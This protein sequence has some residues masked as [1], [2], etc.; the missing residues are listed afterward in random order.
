MR[1]MYDSV[2]ASAIPRSAEMVAGYVDGIY[3]WSPQDWA[4]FPD[5]VKV[6]ISAV[7]ATHLAQV[8]D[9]EQGCIWP[10]ER[11]V[12]LV[13]AARRA[14]IDPTVYVNERN[15]WGPTKAAFDRAGVAHPH[16]WL[17][18]YDGRADY[19]TPGAVARQYAHPHDGDGVADRPWETGGHYDLSAVRDYWPGVDEEDTM[20]QDEREALF[21]IRDI[22]ESANTGGVVENDL[23]NMGQWFR[24]LYQAVISVHRGQFLPL[25]EGDVGGDLTWFQEQSELALQP[26]LDAIAASGGGA[27]PI[28]YPALVAAQ[29]AS[30]EYMRALGEAV[31][32]AQDRNARDNDPTT[33]PTT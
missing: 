12:P 4:R 30:P 18:N 13:V 8:F 11:V 1:T 5:A 26:V 33:G 27:G 7:G 24:E 2:N 29:A 15:D 6:R 19:V 31:A 14:G 25:R 28:D 23:E 32:A 20:A 22:L 3:A 17:A 10:P 16:W 21:R 9:V